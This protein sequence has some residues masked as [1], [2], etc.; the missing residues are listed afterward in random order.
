MRLVTA[1]VL[2]AGLLF[3]LSSLHADYIR[4]S[5]DGTMTNVPETS[6]LKVIVVRPVVKPVNSGYDSLIDECAARHNLEPSLI[7]AVIEAESNYDPLAV[8]PKGA[9]GLMQLMPET[10][11][12]LG[13]DSPFDPEQNIEGGSKYLSELLEVFQGRLDL[14]LAAYNAGP[15]VVGTLKRIPQNRETPR[16]VKKV[17]KVYVDEG[18]VLPET[19]ETKEKGKTEEPKPEPE[20]PKGIVFLCKD[21]EGRT[22]ITNIPV[23]KSN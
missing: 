13:V 15:T 2:L 23:L 19:F 21:E 7:K 1:G 17:L 3:P 11:E 6:D 10:A 20:E 12:M 16:Y 9:M 5:S 4:I 8:S 22:V 14:A 18:G